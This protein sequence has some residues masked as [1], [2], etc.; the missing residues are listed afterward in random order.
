MDPKFDVFWHASWKRFCSDLGPIWGPELA[1]FRAIFDACFRLVFDLVLDTVF[2]LLQ[3]H[4]SGQ[5]GGKKQAKT[6]EGLQF[7][8]F[9]AFSVGTSSKCFW[10]AVLEPFWAPRWAQNRS[11]GAY[12][13]HS[14][15]D[16]P[17]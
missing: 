13:T 6:M 9:S 17:K 4:V 12:R 1:H 8:R 14:E 15:N 11:Q 7:L 2:D 10:G 16:T 5:V 3:G